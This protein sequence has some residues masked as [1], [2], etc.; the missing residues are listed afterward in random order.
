MSRKTLV[1]ASTLVSTALLAQDKVLT[2]SIENFKRTADDARKANPVLALGTGEGVGQVLKSL[3][4]RRSTSTGPVTLEIPKAQLEELER[5]QKAKERAERLA[6]SGP[7]RPKRELP[8]VDSAIP[9]V[10]PAFM[11]AMLSHRPRPEPTYL[12]ENSLGAVAVGKSKTEVLAALGNPVAVSGIQGMEDGALEVLTYRLSA[13]NT[14]AIRFKAGLVT[15]I[16]R[17]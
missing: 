14:V 7:A 17:H 13:Q 5:R 3:T 4:G 11:Q 9:P 15:A 2:E 10:P 1:L 8:P 6:K 12:S 16:S